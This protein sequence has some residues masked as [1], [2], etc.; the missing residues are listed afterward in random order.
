MT[1]RHAERLMQRSALENVGLPFNKHSQEVKNVRAVVMKRLED[2]PK[3]KKR[4][5]I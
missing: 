4:E 1:T 3:E 2:Q 5:L